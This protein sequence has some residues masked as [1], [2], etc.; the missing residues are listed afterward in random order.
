MNLLKEI[1]NTQTFITFSDETDLEELNEY[2]TYF[3][4]SEKGKGNITEKNKGPEKIST[5]LKEPDFS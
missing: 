2:R 1:G 3:V 4:F 5:E